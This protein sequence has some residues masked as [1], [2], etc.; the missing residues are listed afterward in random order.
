[1][2][3]VANTAPDDGDLGTAHGAAALRRLTPVLERH[4]VGILQLALLAA[5]HAVA[6]PRSY[7]P[8]CDQAYPVQLTDRRTTT[9]TRP[10]MYVQCSDGWRR[11]QPPR[12]P[13]PARRSPPSRAAGCCRVTR[14]VHISA[15][16][17]AGSAASPAAV[18][19]C[20]PRDD[21]GCGLISTD[22]VEDRLGRPARSRG[23]GTRRH[24]LAQR[25]GRRRPGQATLRQG[26]DAGYPRKQPP[27]SAARSPLC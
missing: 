26:G 8:H 17:R 21:Q 5:L 10:V 1:M 15:T 7:L 12:R 14:A 16:I 24:E 3:W 11:G 25:Q 2:S 6:G 19:R 23:D 9:A 18:P 27:A 13:W 20:P 4:R 22:T